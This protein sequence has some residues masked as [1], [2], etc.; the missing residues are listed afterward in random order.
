MHLALQNCIELLVFHGVSWFFMAFPNRWFHAEDS[1]DT[2]V[3]WAR[4]IAVQPRWHALDIFGASQ[5]V[6]STWMKEGLRAVSFD[7]KINKGH[8]ICTLGGCQELIRMGLQF[9]S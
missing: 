8:D 7:I 6:S 5:K 2:L 3:A 4:D 9:L 1:F